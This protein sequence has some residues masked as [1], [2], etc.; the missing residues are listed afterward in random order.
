MP[1]ERKEY[2]GPSSV[3]NDDV[4]QFIVASLKED[5]NEGIKKQQHT[6]KHIYDRAAVLDAASRKQI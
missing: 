4:Q 5:A 1:W 6:A 2:V 3:V